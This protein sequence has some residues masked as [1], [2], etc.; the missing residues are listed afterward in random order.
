MGGGTQAVGSGAG[1]M[2]WQLRVLLAVLCAASVANIYYAQPL[3][4]RIGAD[5]SVPTAQL[6][7]VVALA[8]AGYLVGLLLIV[9]LGDLVNR[10][11]LIV[12]QVSAAAA[13]TLV[14]GVAPTSAILLVGVT[15]AGVFSVVVQVAVAYGAALSSPTERGRNV[16]VITSG[17]VVGILLARTVSGLV[18]DLAGWRAVYA[19][20]A[21]LSV[22]LALAARTLLPRDELRGPRSSYLRAIASVLTLSAASRAFRTRAV[23]TLC[24]FASAGVLWSGMALPLTADPWH[25]STTQIGLFGLAGLAGAVGATRAGRWADRGWGQ[26][27]TLVSLV[28]LIGSWTCI[29][30]APRSLLWFL[31][32]VILLDFAVQAVHVTSQNLIVAGAPEAS[33]RIIGSYMAF[34]AVGSGLGAIT[35]ST[36]YHAAGWGA[37]SLL[38]AAYAAAGLTVWTADRLQHVR[39]TRTPA[40]GR[41]NCQPSDRRCA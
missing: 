33:S 3:L 35:A 10:R 2:T 31:I 7:W 19:G 27:V 9:P 5:L 23:I 20:S 26:P 32:G 6:G 15:V 22:L 37:A 18:A 1:E 14:V 34:Y 28:I 40:E 11:R 39:A 16:G 8:Q 4:E 17:V 13:G 29:A 41:R 24:L 36:L 21:L 38:G 25:L 30:Q 12:F